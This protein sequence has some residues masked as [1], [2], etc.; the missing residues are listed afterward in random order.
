MWQ[1]FFQ[2][3]AFGILILCCS[4]LAAAQTYPSKTRTLLMSLRVLVSNPT[5]L[6]D[7]PKA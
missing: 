7:F 6:Y 3:W 1:I 4:F 5:R 2:R